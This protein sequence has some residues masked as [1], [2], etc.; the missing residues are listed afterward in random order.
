MGD[1]EGGGG[2]GI[3]SSRGREMFTSGGYIYHKEGERR[4]GVYYRCTSRRSLACS[5]GVIV[6]GGRVVREVRPH[7]HAPSAG[8]V[9]AAEAVTEAR[10]AAA[11][12]Q[13]SVHTV[14]SSLRA[15]S[16]SAL[17]R[18]PSAASQRRTLFAQ[19]RRQFGYPPEPQGRDFHLPQR[20][21]FGDFL[22]YDSQLTHPDLP[23]MLVYASQ[24]QLEFLRTTETVLSDGKFDVSGPF[25][26]LYTVHGVKRG[27]SHPCLYAFLPSKSQAI[28]TRL[29][30]VLRGKIPNF[31][32]RSWQTDLELAASGAI[33][34]AYRDCNL[35]YC[36]FHLCQ[37]LWRQIQS[38]GLA[39]RYGT[40]GEFSLRV[41][42]LPALAFVLPDEVVEAYEE[43]V[44]SDYWQEALDDYR[45]YFERV[46]LGRAVGRG[47]RRA[48]PFPIGRWNV[49][50][51]TLDGEART[52]NQA[53]GWHRSFAALL[54]SSSPSFWKILE[55]LDRSRALSESSIRDYALGGDVPTSKNKR[56]VL[57]GRRLTNVAQRKA[58]YPTNRAYLEAVANNLTF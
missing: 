6:S 30:Q 54:Q 55:A 20:F 57:S 41:R 18:M 26:Q 46:Y 56:Y 37:A 14:M 44:A 15:V 10:S 28:Y 31:D 25:Q 48:P 42:V 11:S 40:D 47:R 4:D 38:M 8:A 24:T 22:L 23:R 13:T 51:R 27:W 1:A 16:D 49:Y 52:T 21:H 53:E 5:G 12:G 35:T 3:S 19:R 17:V 58:E 36:F 2:G 29:L 9:E 33:S 39:G 50:Q 7:S 32:P 34:A 45:E 43:L